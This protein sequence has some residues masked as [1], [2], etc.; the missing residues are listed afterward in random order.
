MEQVLMNSKMQN[1]VSPLK[2]RVFTATLLI[3]L[4]LAI[5]LFSS[6][7]VFS[8]IA[9]IVI[10]LA[11][12]EWTRLSGYKSLWGRG[13]A[14]LA[15]P[16]MLLTGFAILYQLNRFNFV[17]FNPYSEFN[18]YEP[19]FRRIAWAVLLFWI[20]A[21]IAV[22]L[23]PKGKAIFQY[24]ILNLLIGCFVL[25]PAYVCAVALQIIS[26]RWLLYVIALVCTADIAAYFAGRKWGKRHI[27]PQLSPGKTL[28]GVMGAVV[29]GLLVA[30]IGYYALQVNA[31]L[32]TWF[33][34]NFLTIL[35]S[36]VGDLFE[37]L[38]KR[39]Q[40]LKDSGTLLPGHGGVMDRLD[41]LSAAIPM[42]TIGWMI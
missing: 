13:I 11:A 37:S 21:S 17:A 41:S 38:F 33:L 1:T 22:S 3:P 39:Q 18:S 31:N 8:V 32:V 34:L 30:G 9:G 36:I 24:R 35:F 15:M 40:N 12:W 16:L 5:I 27:S 28:E 42:F 6:T 23:Y 14:L 26:P 20:L 19:I 7:N 2:K 29:A 4:F 10:V 25:L